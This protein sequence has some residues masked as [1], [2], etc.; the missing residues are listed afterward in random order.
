MSAVIEAQNL[1][2]RY[3]DLVAVNDLTLKVEPGEIFGFLGPNEI[4][5]AHV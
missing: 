4:G 2:K 1:T 3:R 5:R